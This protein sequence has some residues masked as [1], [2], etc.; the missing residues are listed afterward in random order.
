MFRVMFHRGSLLTRVLVP[1]NY[2]RYSLRIRDH[3]IPSAYACAPQDYLKLL[4][5]A[6]FGALQSAQ[7]TRALSKN[8]DIQKHTVVKLILFIFAHVDKR[9]T[10]HS[11][12]FG[13]LSMRCCVIPAKLEGEL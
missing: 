1:S 4:F 5:S 10:T 13:T 11:H 12:L 3:K 2:M 8:T 9:E 7:R 6:S